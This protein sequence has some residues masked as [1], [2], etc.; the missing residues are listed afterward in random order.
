MATSFFII[1][2]FRGCKACC[3]QHGWLWDKMSGSVYAGRNR[4]PEAN[5]RQRGGYHTACIYI[6]LRYYYCMY[7]TYVP[8]IPQCGLGTILGGNTLLPLKGGCYS[9]GMQI[10]DF[11]LFGLLSIY[12]LYTTQNA[13]CLLREGTRNSAFPTPPPL[14]SRGAECE[15]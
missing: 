10:D 13:F 2:S 7:S 15:V 11:S 3:C 8:Y 14:R 5:S 9:P 12:T 1:E 6:T 4:K